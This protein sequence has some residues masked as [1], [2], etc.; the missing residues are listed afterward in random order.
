MLYNSLVLSTHNALM[1]LRMQLSTTLL[2]MVPEGKWA[3][4]VEGEAVSHMRSLSLARQ[5]GQF[6]EGMGCRLGGYGCGLRVVVGVE[7]L[8]L[9]EGRGG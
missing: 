9:D 5:W 7:R 4:R 2:G 6:S 3:A 8:R 1:T